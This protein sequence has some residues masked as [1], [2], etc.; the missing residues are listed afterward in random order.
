[1]A[2]CELGGEAEDS[3]RAALT[4]EDRYM[5][6]IRRLDVQDAPQPTAIDQVRSP[7]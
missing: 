7:G 3:M 4:E 6:E 5:L 1:M 2:L